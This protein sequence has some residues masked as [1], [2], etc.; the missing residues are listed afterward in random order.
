M[1]FTAYDI[2]QLAR[3]SLRKSV[4]GNISEN[5]FWKRSI[6][7]SNDRST[8]TRIEEREKGRPKS[9]KNSLNILIH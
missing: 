8:T 3:E 6:I 4:T 2:V 9:G 1:I 5:F 7:L